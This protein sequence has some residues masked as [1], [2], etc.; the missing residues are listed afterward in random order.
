MTEIDAINDML[1]YVGEAA[2][3][4]TDPDYTSHPLYESALRILT[5]TNRAVQAKGWWFNTRERTLPSTVDDTITVLP[6]YLSVAVKR[7]YGAEYTVRAGLMYD[8]T[9]GTSEIGH[10]LDVVIRELVD[11][12]E[13]P[14]TAAE[15]IKESAALRFVQTY[16]GDRS[17][18][19]EVKENR[20]EAY[21]IFNADHIRN[22][23]V[24]LFQTN[25]LGPIIAN[26]W[27]TR[28]RQR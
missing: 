11:F 26:N 12:D 24:N 25:S 9:N 13:I 18:L 1:A 8:L 3:D 15:F 2:I 17:K 20:K 6:R 7:I 23:G 21:V 28:Y 19:A 27:H 10:D 22:V 5:S 16:D 14:E 4:D